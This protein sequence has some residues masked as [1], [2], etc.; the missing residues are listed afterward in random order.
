MSQWLLSFIKFTILFPIFEI[1]LSP[2]DIY[3]CSFCACDR[4]NF[5]LATL[6]ISNIDKIDSAC[7]LTYSIFLLVLHKPEELY[8]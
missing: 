4:I 3:I 1:A 5:L 6:C 2:R 7:C 8:S